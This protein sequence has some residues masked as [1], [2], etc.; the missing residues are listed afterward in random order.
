MHNVLGKP[1]GHRHSRQKQSHLPTEETEGVTL[2]SRHGE[3]KNSA[4]AV[5]WDS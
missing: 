2:K 1:A 5:S 4:R 3:V